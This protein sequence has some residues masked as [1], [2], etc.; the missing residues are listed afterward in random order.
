MI[1][2]RLMRL[3]LLTLFVKSVFLFNDLRLEWWII[4]MASDL[5]ITFDVLV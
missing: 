5:G 1:L 4:V 3:M 2:I